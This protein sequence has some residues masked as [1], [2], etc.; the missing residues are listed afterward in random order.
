MAGTIKTGYISSFL[1]FSIISQLPS[2]F[3]STLHDVSL[4]PIAPLRIPIIFTSKTYLKMYQLRI[5]IAIAPSVFAAAKLPGVYEKGDLGP[6]G[7][8]Y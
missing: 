4:I 5:L 6:V 2:I 3:A 8:K 1:R 7:P